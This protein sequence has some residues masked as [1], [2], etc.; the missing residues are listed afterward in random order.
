MEQHRQLGFNPL[1]YAPAQVGSLC[2]PNGEILLESAHPLPDFPR[3]NGVWL[4]HWA[5]Q[6]PQRT[7]YAERSGE[8]WR[9]VS[10][11]EV[12]RA[13]RS[14]GAALLARGLSATR[15]VAVLSDNSVDHALLALACQYV[16]VPIAPI[17]QAYSLMSKDHAKLKAIFRLLEP[18]LVY[19]GDEAKFAP[20]LAALGDFG[21]DLVSSAPAGRA[22]RLDALLATTAG[23]EV[24]AAFAALGPDTIAKFLFTSGSTGEP[25]GV[26]NTQ[27]MITSNQVSWRTLWPF[28]L[29]VPPV[30]VDWMPWNHTFG[31]NADCNIV[32]V[33]WRHD[34]YRRRQTGTGSHRERL[35]ANLREIAPTMYLNVP[36]GFRHAAA[37]SWK[38]TLQLRQAISFPA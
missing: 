23:P 4:E 13:A 25:K 24:D 31:G 29:E 9:R 3:C 20:T 19:V 11:A 18:G 14:I 34:V 21:F 16:G 7:L 28:L 30:L 32:L 1:H 27:R 26:I 6:A 15:P 22:E 12:L 5:G 38:A 2:R 10:Y 17:S 37:L 35:S 36:R 8:G 33:Q